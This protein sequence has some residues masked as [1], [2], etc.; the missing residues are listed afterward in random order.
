[1][2]SNVI[3]LQVGQLC[4]WAIGHHL[5][6]G[7]PWLFGLRWVG[8]RMLRFRYRLPLAKV[9]TLAIFLEPLSVERGGA[10]WSVVERGAWSV[11][12]GTV[13]PIR[14]QCYLP[15]RYRAV[16]RARPLVHTQG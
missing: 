13:R 1:M 14:P 10:W 15:I 8:M 4:S 2:Y 9:P 6:Y 3:L 16:P 7:F 11:V 5:V 12:R